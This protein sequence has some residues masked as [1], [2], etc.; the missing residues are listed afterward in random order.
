MNLN[1][2]LSLCEL[3]LTDKRSG[4]L[5]TVWKRNDKYLDFTECRETY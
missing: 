4:P 5:P 3:D 1:G 2:R